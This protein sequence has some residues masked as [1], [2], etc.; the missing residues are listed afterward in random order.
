MYNWVI[1][2]VLKSVEAYKATLA[3]HPNSPAKPARKKGR[4]PHAIP[5]CLLVGRSETMSP[6]YSALLGID[7][8]LAWPPPSLR[9]CSYFVIMRLEGVDGVGSAG[10]IANVIHAFQ[11]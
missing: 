11:P 10:E 7:V 6:I 2:P 1:G 8:P 4:E 3:K 5:K 9:S